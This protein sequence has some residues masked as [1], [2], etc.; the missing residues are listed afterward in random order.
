MPDFPFTTVDVFTT[1]RFAGN[2]LA[3]ITDARGL[4]TAAMQAIAREFNYAESTFVFPPTDPANTAHVRI[5]TPEEEMPFAGH[6]NVGTGFVLARLGTLFG[7]PVP[8]RMIFEEA[9]GLVPVTIRREAGAITGA[10]VRAPRPLALG[11]IVD[12]VRV[13]ALAGLDPADI[14]TTRHPPRFASVGAEFLIAEVGADAL[15][16]ARC[17]V[18]AFEAAEGNIGQSAGL[19]GLHLYAR[20]T[21]HIEVRMFAPLAGVTEDPAT[22]SAAAA[23]GAWLNALDPAETRF[24]LHQGRHVRRPSLI[25]VE[26]GPNAVTVGGPCVP[27]MAGMLHL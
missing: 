14:L 20:H 5:F 21:D 3:V 17:N 18:A 13:A 12:P 23:L 27:V 1:S 6:P 15:A 24:T 4:D 2:P 16:R 25:E 22:G 10:T 8:D 19:L 26:A 7:R 9:A 11:T